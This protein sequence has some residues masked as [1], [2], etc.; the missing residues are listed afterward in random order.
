MFDCERHQ[1]PN[2]VG[3][4]LF[5][6]GDMYAKL[7]AFRDQQ[8]FGRQ[9]M[10]PLYFAKVDVQSCFDTIPQRGALKVMEKL[11]S[12]DVY[13]IARHAQ[14]KA[15]DAGRSSSNLYA[16]A[17]P[18][19]KFLASA[20]PP[21]DFRSFDEIVD[22]NLAVE[23]KNTVFVD[24]VLRTAH[25]KQKLLNLLKDHVERNIVKIGKKFF[26]QKEGIPQGSVLSSLL[27][28]CFYAKLE[29][30][31]LPF[32]SK[33]SAVLMRLIDDFL[34]ITTCKQDAIWF[35]Q[36]MHDGIEEYGVKV[37][38][39]KSLVNFRLKI[40][41]SML[42]RVSAFKIQ[43]NKMFLDTNFNSVSNVISNVYQNF[44]E[45]AMK[46]YRYVKS[47]PRDKQPHA[48]LLIETIESVMELAFVLIKA[49]HKSPKSHEYNCVLSKRQ[50]QWLALTAFRDV[51][52]RKQTKFR[53]VLAW[54]EQAIL[55]VKPRDGKDAMR[56]AKAVKKGDVAF[57]CY[58]Y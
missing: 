41:G 37:N 39:A 42:K 50:V 58:R 6:V 32:V 1:S 30:E 5:S 52:S 18:A 17:K 8:C 21:L 25:K 9:G 40:N 13:R 44:L 26:R 51:L 27:C 12:E 4:A 31:H 45:A 54:V 24:N 23:K 22:E 11:A 20:H 3:S 46:Y 36:I 38:P 33:T 43:T 28:N 19:R 56:L 7:K 53:Q 16:Q 55:D 29:S 15:S 47:L 14:I 49:K 35:L 10:S 2:F 48:A 57:R 34:F